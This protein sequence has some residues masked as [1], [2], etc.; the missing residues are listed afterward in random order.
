MTTFYLMGLSLTVSL[1]LVHLRAKR[2]RQQ[3]EATYEAW[4]AMLRQATDDED[5]ST[6]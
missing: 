3:H 6:W 4:R 2:R 1:Y 5:K